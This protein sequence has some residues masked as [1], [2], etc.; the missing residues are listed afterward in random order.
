MIQLTR[1]KGDGNPVAFTHSTVESVKYALY[2]VAPGLHQG[3]R[4]VR[5][6]ERSVDRIQYR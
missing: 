5:R 3:T 1:L 4:A 6:E 2:Q